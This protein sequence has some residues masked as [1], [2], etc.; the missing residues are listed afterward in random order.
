MAFRVKYDDIT[1]TYLQNSSKISQWNEQ[2]S[3]IAESLNMFLGL[4]S[5]KGTTAS[6]LKNYLA[7]VH[8]TILVSLGEVLNEF[9]SRFLLYKEGYSAEIDGDLHAELHEETLDT[10]IAFFPISEDCFSTQHSSLTSVSSSIAD[11]MGAGIPSDFHV[12]DS[13]TT[14]LKRIKELK[15]D[16][17]TYE[18][19]H[20]SSDLTNFQDLLSAVRAFIN[21]YLGQDAASI[22]NYQAGSAVQQGSF[23]TLENAI[24][25]S[26]TTRE[27]LTEELI[28]ASENEAARMEILEAEWAK[29]REEAGLW[30]WIAGAGAVLVGGICI[31]ATAG[32]ATPLVVAGVVAGSSAIAYGA[33]EMYE[34]Q[35]EMDYGRAGDPYTVSFNPIRDTIFAGNQDAYDAWGTVST[36]VAGILIPVGQGYA[37][38]A[39]AAKSAGTTLTR[40]MITRS[41]AYEVGKDLV[42]AGAGWGAT[43]LGTQVG[44]ELFGTEAGKYIGIAS[45]I[46]AGFGTNAVIGRLDKV[47]NISGLQN[48]APPV[49]PK[50]NDDVLTDGSHIQDGQLQ[51]NV[52]YQTGEYGYQYS[53]DGMGRIDSFTADDLHLT[54]R[55]GR[56]RHNAN[57]PGKVAGDHAGHLAGD[58]F[59]GSPDIDNLISQDGHV[60]LSS[61]KKLENQWA[62]AIENGQQVSVRIDVNYIGDSLRPVSFDIEYLIDG[63]IESI[64][65]LN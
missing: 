42:S 17:G 13:Y 26:Y 59:G 57:T 18:T 43:Q 20:Y 32:A 21:D 15:E 47:L 45:G 40:T 51:P 10:L 9:Q 55:S 49:V 61:Y 37:A 25:N 16:T 23:S 30:Q 46:L 29:Q 24:I 35:Q 3:A 60:N 11:I 38:A 64:S 63:A 50:V 31:I 34:G 65:L 27:A 56:L 52:K 14:V 39:N 54:E 41:V 12:H 62:A 53:T 7:D 22:M 19:T 1:Y 28:T 2:M 58:R 6:C 5:F 44:T 48:L 36:T 8:F 33:A 4:E